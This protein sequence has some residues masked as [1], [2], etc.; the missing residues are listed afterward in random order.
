MPASFPNL[1]TVHFRTVKG[2]GVRNVG[3]ITDSQA[4]IELLQTWL[5][6]GGNNMKCERCNGTGKIVFQSDYARRNREI[7]CYECDGTGK[8]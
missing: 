5:M 3:C 8:V 7:D 1:R 6:I 2:A 4:I